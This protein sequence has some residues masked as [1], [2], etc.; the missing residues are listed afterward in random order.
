MPIEIYAPKGHLDIFT[1]SSKITIGERKY[2]IN[3][4]TGVLLGGTPYDGTY[5][6]VPTASGQVMPTRSKT[7]S[8]DVTIHPIPYQETSNEAGGITVSIA[9]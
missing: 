6:I 1:P 7:M 5:E 9:S 3:I 2:G 8:D 4:V